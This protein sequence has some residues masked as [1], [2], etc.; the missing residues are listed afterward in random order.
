[1]DLLL[2][3]CITK[4]CLL[5]CCISYYITLLFPLKFRQTA[6]VKGP[7]FG[8]NF[9]PENNYTGKHLWR[10]HFQKAA[11][12]M[13]ISAVL[14][15]LLW[16]LDKIRYIL[17]KFTFSYNKLPMFN[18]ST[19]KH[20][21]EYYLKNSTCE[22]LPVSLSVEIRYDMYTNTF[23]QIKAGHSFEIC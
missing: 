15:L 9:D 6:L 18:K 13:N 21:R 2:K 16:W 14:F 10:N 4:F 23:E 12:D 3:K 19:W 17:E 8:P 5:L 7:N 20:T 1:M 11:S 22:T